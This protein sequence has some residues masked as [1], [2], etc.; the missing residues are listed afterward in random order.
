[1]I[2]D[3]YGSELPAR[4]VGLYRRDQVLLEL[5]AMPVYL[6]IKQHIDVLALRGCGRPSVCINPDGPR[7][8]P[9][10]VVRFK[11]GSHPFPRDQNAVDRK[12]LK[13]SRVIEG[14]RKNRRSE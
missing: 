5:L 11:H 1:A 9:L 7:K 10:A 13:Q 2:T 4:Q 14:M 6:I 3:G 12:S 8:N